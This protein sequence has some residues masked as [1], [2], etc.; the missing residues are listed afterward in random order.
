MTI[1]GL[2]HYHGFGLISLGYVRL[3]S[4]PS[5]PTH[6]SLPLLGNWKMIRASAMAATTDRQE[7]S[8]DW[9]VTGCDE[10]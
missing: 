1:G 2:R 4:E 9:Q 10:T 6:G 7:I 5:G 8:S 3:V